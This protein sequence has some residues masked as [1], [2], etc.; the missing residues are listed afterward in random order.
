M[1]RYETQV[2]KKILGR[3]EVGLEKYGTTLERKDFTTKRWLEE[4]QAELLDG[5]I[6]SERLIEL[7]SYDVDIDTM[8]SVVQII[9]KIGIETVMNE[10]N[11]FKD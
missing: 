2:I 10:L 1:S 11:K 3:A 8:I 6:Y 9:Q 4:L 5:S 7:F